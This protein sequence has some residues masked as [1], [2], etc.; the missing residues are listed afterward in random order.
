M[1]PLAAAAQTTTITCPTPNAV[2]SNGVITVTGTTQ[3]GS[4]PYIDSVHFSLNDG[5]LQTPATVSSGSTNGYRFINWSAQNL[6]LNPGSNTFRAYGISAYPPDTVIFLPTNTVSF[7]SLAP[8]IT[9]PQRLSPTQ[10]GFT[11]VGISNSNYTVQFC[12]NLASTNWASLFSLTLTNS[13]VP[14]VDLNATNRSRYYRVVE[15]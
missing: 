11:V 14:V 3:F 12:T 15:N 10:F 2:I 1:L 6:V 9:Q 5:P 7:T 8:A 4:N 13:Q